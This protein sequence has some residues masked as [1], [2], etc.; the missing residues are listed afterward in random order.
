MGSQD[1][2]RL[3]EEKRQLEVKVEDLQRKRIAT[4]KKLREI[5][6]QI[7]DRKGTERELNDHLRHRILKKQL[8]ECHMKL[9]SLKE[10]RTQFERASYERQ[11]ETLKAKQEE[12]IDEVGGKGS[13]GSKLWY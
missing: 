13:E 7:L 3:T 4:D 2:G 9:T 11:M 10:Q 6:K 5:E 1:L 12:L 8:A